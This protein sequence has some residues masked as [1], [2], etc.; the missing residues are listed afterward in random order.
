MIKLH[1]FGDYCHRQPLAYQPIQQIT[2]SDLRLTSDMAE[3][4]IVLVAHTKDLETH[5]AALARQMQPDQRLVLLS[6]EPFW[7]TVWGRAPLTR[8]QTLETMHGILAVTVLNHATSSI[9]EFLKIPY[10]LLTD[11]A[12]FTRYSRWFS[13]NAAR[14][15]QEWHDLFSAARWD[16]AFVA[17]YRDED[18]FD[19]TFDD[20]DL[21]GIA[22]Y[23]TQVALGCNTGSV[24]RMGAGW[25]ALP[26]RQTLPDWHL[27]KFLDLDGQCRL[28]SA[29]ENT[30]Q[31]TYISEKLFDSFALGAVPIYVA[32][33]NHRATTIV[34][35]G[36]F[37]NMYGMGPTETADAIMSFA[38]DRAFWDT[39]RAAQSDLAQ[40][41]N[42]GRALAEEQDRLAN[43][44]RGELAAVL[45]S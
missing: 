21:F 40:L 20:P 24:L 7:D 17:E 26:R 27:E 35:E 33:P 44:L 15:L 18:R 41:F 42:S 45:K 22:R 28:L 43:A 10:F 36:A 13:R 37:L 9:Y 16:A 1:P 32:G 30:H 12:F 4:D 6:E 14:D 38:P 5:G 34:P 2:Q 39:Y 31:N 11:R 19:C 8:H 29:M 25:N 3:A 23:R